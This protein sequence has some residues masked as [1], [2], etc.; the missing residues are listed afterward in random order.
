MQKLLVGI[1]NPAADGDHTAINI[2]FADN[3]RR[4]C[5]PHKSITAVCLGI[6][7]N[8]Q[9]FNKYLSGAVLPNSI[10]LH[11]ICRFLKVSE[12]D[13][14]SPRKYDEPGLRRDQK[15]ETKSGTS[16]RSLVSSSQ[17]LRAEVPGLR[18]GYY[19]CYTVLPTAPGIVAR[20]LIG[21][22]ERPD[23]LRFTRMTR[24][25][26]SAVT[27]PPKGI[28]KHRGTVFADRNQVLF[29]GMS[30]YPAGLLT[31]LTIEQGNLR[32]D[33][34]TGKLMTRS[35][36]GPIFGNCYIKRLDT[37][38]SLRRRVLQIGLVHISHPDLPAGLM[39]VL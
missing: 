16:F 39:D 10:T 38:G 26:P 14:L 33:G 28:A 5:A 1:E 6:S 21:I 35:V 30:H 3:L 18:P 8:R 34:C 13:L 4:A 11:R 23:E 29:V 36:T 9:Q 24:I 12:S 2:V 17:A 31:I 19:E 27:Y 7:I 25:V 15:P 22:F 20:S 32:E 37:V